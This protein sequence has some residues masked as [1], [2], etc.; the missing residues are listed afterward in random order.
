MLCSGINPFS[1]NIRI[2]PLTEHFKISDQDMVSLQILQAQLALSQ[3]RPYTP[4][5]WNN[6]PALPQHLLAQQVSYTSRSVFKTP[7]SIVSKHCPMAISF[8]FRSTNI[9][10]FHVVVEFVADTI[11]F[12]IYATT[13][14]P[15]HAHDATTGTVRPLQFLKMLFL[16]F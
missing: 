4:N 10:H 6:L 11:E 9:E 14:A 7:N 13:S 1:S 8:N 15:A 2:P 16:Y 12:T 5:D 3:A